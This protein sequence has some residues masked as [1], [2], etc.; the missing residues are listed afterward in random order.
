MGAESSTPA[1]GRDD[2]VS[3]GGSDRPAADDRSLLRAYEPV[4]RLTAGEY[5]VPVAVDGFVAQSQLFARDLADNA[6]VLATPGTLDLDRLARLGVEH[7]GPG[8]SLSGI[9]AP[10]TLSGRFRA[11]LPKPRPSF[12]AGSRLAQVGLFGRSIDF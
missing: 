5:F 1:Q 8:L 4:L 10:T 3:T 6:V 12:R 7:D 9:I 11:W 2:S